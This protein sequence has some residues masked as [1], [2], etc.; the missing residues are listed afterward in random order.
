MTQV[1]KLGIRV[2]RVVGD[3]HVARAVR[4]ARVVGDVHV[5][6]AV[7][8]VCVF[9][10]P[11]V[12]ALVVSVP[13]VPASVVPVPQRDDGDWRRPRMPPGAGHV[14]RLGKQMRDFLARTEPRDGQV[15]ANLRFGPSM[16]EE[17]AD[18]GCV[19]SRVR[20]RAEHIATELQDFR[21]GSVA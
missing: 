17:H 12:P 2:T 6:R 1:G 16:L 5:A 11:V 21:N 13:G 9:R 8:A 3:V 10:V 19:Q 20:K 14:P 7:R 4:V 18:E 15:L